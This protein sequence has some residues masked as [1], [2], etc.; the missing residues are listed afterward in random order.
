M[1]RTKDQSLQVVF[2]KAEEALSEIEDSRLI[3]KLLAIKG[4]AT[5]E[6]KDIASIIQTQTRTI[7]KWVQQFRQGGIDGLRDKPKGHRQALLNEEQKQEIAKWLDSSKTPDGTDINW[8]LKS[9]CYYIKL[10][11]GVE[12]KKSAWA[13][14]LK[15][16]NY[17]F[18]RPRPTH[19]KGSEVE[20]DDFKKNLD[21]I[22]LLRKRQGKNYLFL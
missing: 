19:A 13:N 1:S 4:Y 10:S 5:H 2:L 7:Y 8:T 9:L 3:I 14:T 15:K 6:A 18:R 20:K 21:R 17:S 16:M 12:I 22:K 11:L